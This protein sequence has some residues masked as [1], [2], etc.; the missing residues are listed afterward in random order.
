LYDLHRLLCDESTDPHE[1]W[2]RFEDKAAHRG[3]NPQLFWDRLEIR[4]GQY[5]TRWEHEMAGY[6][7]NYPEFGKLIREL[8]RLLRTIEL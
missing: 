3:I 6:V 2:A 5:Q 1:A 8:R 4:I 7:Q